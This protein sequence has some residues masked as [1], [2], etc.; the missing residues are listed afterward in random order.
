MAEKHWVS[1]ENLQAYHTKV[2]GSK[3]DK[4]ADPNGT[5]YQRLNA[6]KE[7]IGH[8]LILKIT[9]SEEF[10]GKA[11]TV[12]GNGE[13]FTG[14][15]PNSLYVNL[16]V[17]GLDTIYTVSAEYESETYTSEVETKDF[18]GVYFGELTAWQATITVTVMDKGVGVAGAKVTAASADKT[19]GPVATDAEGKVTIK[20]GKAGTY[21]VTAANSAGEE[22]NPK[23]VEI[24]T[25]GETYTCDLYYNSLPKFTY[26]GNYE[27]VNDAGET[28]T[29]SDA[30]WK[31][32]LLTSG[33]LNFSLLATPVDV[34][35]VGGGGGGG[36]Y[37]PNSGYG[38][39]GGGGYTTTVKNVSIESNKDYPVVIGAGGAYT[40]NGTASTFDEYT[41]NFG[42]GSPN[43]ADGGNGGSGGGGST[44]V[45]GGIDGA[46]GANGT[47]G[48]G[49]KGQGTTTRE[50]GEPTGTLYSTG[51]KGGSYDS[52]AASGAG[53]V[54]N[55]KP[56]TGD[57]GWGAPSWGSGS[58]TGG[59][60]GSG[61]VIIRNARS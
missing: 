56:N 7:I 28:A 59:T 29:E 17:H 10:K 11:Y 43:Y 46:D 4:T 31:L 38:G 1:E 55:G 47:H 54:V 15:V 20:I 5:I 26:D 8:L 35:L 33:T 24:T 9:F 18:Y 16:H 13:T 48:S 6:Q 52:S 22:T 19:Y 58:N 42:Y 25:A 45:A 36:Y 49:G 3:T 51:G 41:G 39:G 32:R 50:F 2:V 61:I 30:N 14:T 44:N 37:K 60:G 57:G 12:T 34:F 23:P 27:L 53:T 40:K 21:T